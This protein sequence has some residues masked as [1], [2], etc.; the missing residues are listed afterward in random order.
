MAILAVKRT[1]VVLV[2]C[3]LLKVSNTAHAQAEE[4]LVGSHPEYH[5]AMVREVDGIFVAIFVPKEPSA[6][7]SPV[8]METMAP[9]CGSKQ[10]IELHATEAIMAFGATPEDRLSEVRNAVQ[11]FFD[12]RVKEC[13]LTADFEER[14]FHRFDGAYMAT[15]SLLVEAG[16]FPA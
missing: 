11:E 8:L 14:F 15:D 4:W 6:Y 5:A 3:A 16:I 1:L 13:P 9:V 7:F 12:Q 10:P 2:A